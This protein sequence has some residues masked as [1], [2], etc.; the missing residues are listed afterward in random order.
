MADYKESATFMP[1]D[2]IV[3]DS[4]LVTDREGV[5]PWCCLTF[6]YKVGAVLVAAHH[7][8]SLSLRTVNTAK[9]PSVYGEVLYAFSPMSTSNYISTGKQWQLACSLY[10]DFTVVFGISNTSNALNT[11]CFLVSRQPSELSQM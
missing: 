5:V 9:E 10:G 11:L 3:P 2:A 6:S 8:L 1:I 7:E 4:F